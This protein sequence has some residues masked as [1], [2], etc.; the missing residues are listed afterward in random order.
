MDATLLMNPS[1]CNSVD[2]PEWIPYSNV[3]KADPF[4]ISDGSIMKSKSNKLI[5]KIVGLIQNMK[6]E[7]EFLGQATTSPTTYIYSAVS[8]NS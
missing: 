7:E 6:S 5:E 4:A 1:G 3:K 8:H 2:E